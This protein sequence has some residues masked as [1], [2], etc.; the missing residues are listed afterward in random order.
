[1]APINS[2][3]EL[4]REVVPDKDKQAEIAARLEEVRQNVYMA[5]LNTKTI[6]WVDA[7]HKMGRQL[8]GFVSLGVGAYLMHKHPD[9]N[10]AS[11][12]ALLAPGGIYNYVKGK[13]Q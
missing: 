13:G 5:E 11:L 7:V 8:I 3:L 10:P 2:L 9:I 12:A 4:I 1:M 6:P